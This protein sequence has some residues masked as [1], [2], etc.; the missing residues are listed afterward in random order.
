MLNNPRGGGSRR[1]RGPGV[2]GQ[3]VDSEGQGKGKEAH[4]ASGQLLPPP[5]AGKNTGGG[6]MSMRI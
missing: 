1:D 2:G 5:G 4:G 6:C 3:R